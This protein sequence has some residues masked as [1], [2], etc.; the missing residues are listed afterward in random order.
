MAFAGLYFATLCRTVF[1]YDSAEYVTAAY[2]LGIPHPPGY[3]LYTIIAHVFTW[4]PVDPALAVAA[5]S[6]VFGAVAVGLMHLL[7]LRVGASLLAATAGAI[8]LGASRLFWFNSLIAESYVPGL[9]FLLAVLL[10]L[11][12]GLRR[13]RAWP[14]LLA[15][16]LAGLS[17]GVHL[18]NATAGLGL[19]LLVSSFRIEVARPRDL[20]AIFSRAFLRQRLWLA[21]GAL[22]A[23]VLGAC[24]FLYLPIRASMEPVYN[25]G[26]PVT[27][28]RFLWHITGGNYGQLFTSDFSSLAQGK[29]L[30]GEFA[31]QLTIPG[32]LLAL[33]GIPAMFRWN[34]RF[35][36]GLFLIAVGNTAFFFGYRA[37]DQ[38][39]FFLITTMMLAA[40]AGFGVEALLRGLPAVASADRRR[41]FERLAKVVAIV[42][43]LTLIPAHYRDVDM[44][45]FDEAERYAQTMAETLPEGAL[46]VSFSTPVEW[47]YLT[48]FGLYYRKVRGKRGDVSIFNN[49]TASEIAARIDQG[50]PVFMYVPEPRVAKAGFRVEQ[51]GIAFQIT[52]Y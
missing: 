30:I 48:V 39:D 34:P 10:L 9:C 19:A 23:A 2:F 11:E 25:F 22:G 40:F 15:A 41:T 18:S 45:D 3:P 8:I 27:L 16:W 28:D 31:G 46:L 49:P 33:L 5:M 24:I 43:P 37:H 20:R 52:G 4:L 13:E 36:A 12:H 1:W 44:S 21:A 51:V 17:L 6:A 26:N 35:A 32:L 50:I 47:Q 7:L 14:L 38:E 42:L 29:W